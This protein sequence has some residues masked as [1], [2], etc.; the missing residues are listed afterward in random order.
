MSA[1]NG[2]KMDPQDP[3][4]ELTEL[5]GNLILK[6]IV[7]MKIFQL[8]KSRWTALKDKIINVPVNE[9]DIVNTITRLPR[10][11]LEAGLIEVDLKRK[12]E[13]QNSHKKQLINPE[14]C[15]RMLELL[16]RRKNPHY[17]FYDDYNTYTERC[18]QTD[19]KGYSFIFDE[20]VEPIIDLSERKALDQNVDELEAKCSE[21]ILDLEYLKKDPVR[22]FQFDEYNK[23]LC[24][25]NMYPEMGP[26]NSV[27]VAPGEGKIPQNILHD[28]DWDIKA[29]PHINSPDGKYGLHFERETKLSNQ[30]YFIQRIC[31]QNLKFAKSPAYVY[32]AVAH[33]E[34]KQ[35]QRNINLSYSRGKQTSD[36]EGMK[37]LKLE[38]PYA[39]LDD[40][41]QTPRYWKKAKYEMFAKL[42]NLGPFQ[43]FFTL[44]CADLRWDENFAAILRTQKC[45]LKYTIEEDVDG[46]PRTSISVEHIK[47][48][49]LRTDPIKIYIKEHIDESLH[50]C[51]R[52]NVL[53]AT[54]Y[55]NH[56]VK[57]FMNN[58]VMGGGNPMRVDKFSYKTEFQDRGAGHVHGVLW[59]KLYE[60]EKLCRLRDNNLVSLT[61][62][63]KKERAGEF[64]EPF[65]G[66]KNA[67]RKFRTEEEPSEE[68]EK[69][70]INFIDQFTTVSLCAD[71]V[72]H[73]VVR[74]AEEVNKHHHTKTCR[75]LP[76]CRFRYPKFPIWKTIL[77]KP[78]NSE[79]AEEK[80]HFLRKYAETLE[81][82][83]SLL[84]DEE[85]I[86]SIMTKY[87]KKTESKK[88]YKINR[89]KRILQL[90]EIAEISEEDY[91]E[92][93]SSQ[94][95][96]YSVHLKRD[97]DE[98]Y[99]NS[100]N[101][102]WI[103]AWDGNIDIQPVFDFFEVI[104]YVTEYFT[105]DESGTAE[106]LKQVIENNP[107]DSTKEKMKKIASTFLSH[108]QIGEAEAF[109]KL[110]PDL[111]L[112]N[113][114]VT[115]QWLPLG[116]KEER[117]TRMKRVDEETKN[118]PTLVKLEGIEGLW[119]EQPDILSK[120][121]RRDDQ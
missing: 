52:G 102:E 41:K 94:R 72:G 1:K 101:P 97:I 31:N 96:G 50:E 14:K 3:E 25:S 26:E 114:N 119:Y 65:K 2:L 73:E 18:R 20:D 32:A 62:Q 82:V 67:F 7:F 115:C 8:P 89:K 93:L 44:S 17:Q 10:T 117:Y 35:I 59:I 33:T 92:A 66:I 99:I 55:F 43:F 51:I 40:I 77:V 15:F 47:N 23:S 116:R 68:E 34:L 118:D 57:A 71:E 37:T 60:I 111:L 45:S 42:D 69:V 19:R 121:K 90:L 48:G 109:Y 87:N 63:E 74:I 56:R 88:E 12:V 108:R 36:K 112:K 95:V 91:L 4:L 104:T 58:I 53:L 38:D 5:E 27:I 106:V 120:Y 107:D 80:E 103:Q 100:Y 28:D 75:K 13:Y 76:K 21:E 85:L 9:D 84:E 30:Y 6:R 61:K 83:Q 64:H 113:S 16:K 81:K 105:K 54:R 46:N 79:F 98:I 22:K 29:F 49:K 24:M 70:V 86:T 110:L 78:Y 11:P 39:V